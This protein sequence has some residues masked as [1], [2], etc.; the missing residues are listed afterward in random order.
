M[1]RRVDLMSEEVVA[2]TWLEQ[3]RGLKSVVGVLGHKGIE[4]TTKWLS[5]QFDF[6]PRLCHR[7]STGLALLGVAGLFGNAE[8][9][10]VEGCV[11]KE[12]RTMFVDFLAGGKSGVETVSV[13]DILG[14]DG[15]HYQDNISELCAELTLRFPT[16][17]RLV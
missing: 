3:L 5:A 13:W 15:G 6:A 10:R 11:R 4:S 2:G 1:A 9:V 7:I 12:L 8:D 14:W 17:T 16:K